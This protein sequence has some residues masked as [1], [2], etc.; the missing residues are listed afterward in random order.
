[1]GRWLALVGVLALAGPV[2]VGC[3]PAR[4]RYDAVSLGMTA[5]E[6]EEILGTPGYQFA[7]E[8][9]YTRPDP[10]DLTIVTLR[11]Q[12]GRVAEKAWRNPEKPEEDHH[13]GPARR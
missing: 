13:D 2:L 1:M 5:R 9:V 7:D 3:G 8:W 6:V 12:E 4:A 10:R 11:F